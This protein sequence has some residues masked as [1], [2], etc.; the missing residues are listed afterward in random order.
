MCIFHSILL[1]YALVAVKNPYIHCVDKPTR[2]T[3]SYKWSLFFN[4]LLYMFRT[5][6]CP[7]SGAPSSKLYHAFG[8]LLRGCRKYSSPSYNH[9]AARLACT[10]V[11]NA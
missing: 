1:V 7:S 4:V 9:V 11:P 10:N 3:D 5:I 8:T 2:C 6:A